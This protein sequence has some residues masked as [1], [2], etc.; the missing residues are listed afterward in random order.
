ME[1]WIQ[2]NV[3]AKPILACAHPKGFGWF[4]FRKHRKVGKW[5]CVRCLL[6]LRPLGRAGARSWQKSQR[7]CK[8]TGRKPLKS[9]TLA[10]R[11]PNSAD[12][13]AP[14]LAQPQPKHRATHSSLEKATNC[15]ACGGKGSKSRKLASW[16]SKKTVQMTDSEILGTGFWDSRF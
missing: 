11:K 6:P 4:T 3:V 5:L 9:R 7:R 16:D 2:L 12:A 14:R 8:N 1:H 10:S 15:A 13:K